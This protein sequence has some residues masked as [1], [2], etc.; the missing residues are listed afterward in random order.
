MSEPV[1]EHHVGYTRVLRQR[2]NFMR[3]YINAPCNASIRP[4]TDKA[5]YHKKVAYTARLRRAYAEAHILNNM[6]P[7]INENELIVGRPD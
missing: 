4:A 1:F 3:G 6:E 2:L 7:M 5:A